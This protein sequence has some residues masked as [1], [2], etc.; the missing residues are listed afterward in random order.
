[1][2]LVWLVFL[3]KNTSRHTSGI[4]ALV[5]DGKNGLR[6]IPMI[7]IQHCYQEANKYAATLARRGALLPQDFVIFL[8][9]PA[10]VLFL[11]SLDV[12]CLV[13]I[14]ASFLPKKRKK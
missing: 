9:P 1:M 2:P 7:Q 5:S 3:K 4:G 14:K 12:S 8:E 13:F 10:E 6:E 11:L